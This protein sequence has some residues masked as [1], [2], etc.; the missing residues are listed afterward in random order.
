MSLMEVNEAL[1]IIQEAAHEDANIIFGAVVDPQLHGRVKITV[2]ATGFDHVRADRS[3]IAGGTAAGLPTP[4]D[5]GA[6]AS[7]AR[8]VNGPAGQEAAGGSSRVVIARRQ[9][10]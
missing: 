8:A 4:V 9:G 5:M 7:H 6:Y 10:L 1:T 3:I 2:I